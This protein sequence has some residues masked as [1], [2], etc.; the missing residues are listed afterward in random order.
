MSVLALYIVIKAMKHRRE[1]NGGG[2][3]TMT[4]DKTILHLGESTKE[5]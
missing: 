2:L 1:Q 4:P 3:F 5:D